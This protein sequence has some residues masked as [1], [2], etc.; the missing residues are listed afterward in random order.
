M[1]AYWILFVLP[2]LGAAAH[3]TVPSRKV[4]RW[5]ILWWGLLFVLALIIGLR[6]E[7]GGD[8]LNYEEILG[9]IGHGSFAD[10]IERGDPAYSALNWFA[11]E[12]GAGIYF[13]NLVCATIFAWGLVSFCQEQPRPW[14][15]LTV[16]IPYLVVVVAM[17][18][19]RQGVAIGL[20]MLALTSLS[21][22][23]LLRFVVFVAMAAAFHKSAVILMPLALLANTRSRAWTVAWVA[24]FSLVFYIL[25]V[26]DSVEVMASNY[27]E[28]ELDSAGATVRVAMNA[29]PA[30]IFL[31]FRRR[32]VMTSNERS[33]WTWMSLGAIGLLVVLQLSNASTAVDRIALYWIP[34]Q[35]FVLSRLPDALGGGIMR[36]IPAT[37]AIV[38]YS[39]AV[40]IVWLNFADNAFAWVPYRFYPVEFWD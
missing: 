18:Y 35:L 27:L 2:A 38:A 24:L 11:A 9:V 17:G 39:G 22:G 16:S 31:C 1:I 7:V 6:H 25:L 28:G 37:L 23:R 3:A 33:F 40:M 20:G 34:L 8:W 26:Q 4:N 12:I 30:L 21:S 13:V 19:T 5:P 10:A 15:A 29:V 32:F 36:N 14:L